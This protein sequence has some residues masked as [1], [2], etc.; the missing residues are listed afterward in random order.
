[1]HAA[2]LGLERPGQTVGERSRFAVRPLELRAGIDL[3][4]AHDIAVA[5]PLA[6]QR[7]ISGST[8]RRTTTSHG[9]GD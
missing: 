8:S 2:D 4:L 1:M 6:L 9:T 5:R 7:A 3:E